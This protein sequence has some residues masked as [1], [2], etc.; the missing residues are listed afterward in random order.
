MSASSEQGAKQGTEGIQRERKTSPRPWMA[1]ITLTLDGGGGKHDGEKYTWVLLSTAKS[2][3]KWRKLMG[4]L[5][6]FT[7]GLR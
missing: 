4:L 6:S 7:C 1:N 5:Y 3:H 2:R